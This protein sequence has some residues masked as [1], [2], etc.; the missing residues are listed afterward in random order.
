MNDDN[1]FVNQNVVVN[2]TMTFRIVFKKNG[3]IWDI[4]GATVTLFLEDPNGDRQGYL[5]TIDDGPNGVASY[6]VD[7]T[8]LAIPGDWVK[9]W[10]IDAPVNIEVWSEEVTFTVLPHL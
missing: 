10:L 1:C 4:S 7:D 8:V 2:N 6:Q 9:Q 5:A 3:S